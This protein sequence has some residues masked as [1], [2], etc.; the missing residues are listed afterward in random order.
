MNKT[1]KTPC[2]LFVKKTMDIFDYTARNGNP[3]CR[4]PYFTR[5]ETCELNDSYVEEVMH[6][7]CHYET[8]HACMVHETDEQYSYENS[9]EK[10]IQQEKE[11]ENQLIDDFVKQKKGHVCRQNI[12]YNRHTREITHFYDPELCLYSQC[13]Y[14]D[15]YQE[16]LTGA[17]TNIFY[18][19]KIKYIEHGE[20]LILD[21]QKETI[22]KNKK[23]TQVPISKKLAEIILKSR[24]LDEYIHYK[25]HSRWE[26]DL[27]YERKQLLSVEV[28][29]IRAE[30][31]V[32]HDIYEDL[33]AIK[34][35]ISVSYSDIELKQKK[36]EKSD[37]RAKAKQEK[38]DKIKKLYIEKGYDGLGNQER[39]F[40]KLVDSGE[41]DWEELDKLHEEYLEQ[42]QS[43]L[44][45]F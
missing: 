11:I 28:F 41:L 12:R 34:S 33:E 16:N 29:N 13:K 4:C 38:I 32:K 19:L 27:W 17:K 24:K 7:C 25:E 15:V 3:T 5:T 6:P 23:I 31:K 10:L 43:Q 2:G 9:V 42:Q 36:Q 20:G 18:D 39:K 1:F 26:R 30:I 40:M 44:S 22:V 45:L 14:C 35:G 37:R 21:V 8:I